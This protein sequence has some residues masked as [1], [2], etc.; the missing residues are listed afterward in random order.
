MTVAHITVSHQRLVVAGV[1]E[2]CRARSAR[3]AMFGGGNQGIHDAHYYCTET[4][5]YP[6]NTVLTTYSLTGPECSSYDLHMLT[7][8]PAERPAAHCFTMVSMAA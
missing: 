6:T 3:G 7:H 4:L 2:R 8:A 5:Y 1:A